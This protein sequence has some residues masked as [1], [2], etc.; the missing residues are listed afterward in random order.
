M[1]AMEREKFR[2]SR[3]ECWFAVFPAILASAV[4]LR[5]FTNTYLS[6]W[7]HSIVALL[8]FPGFI[9]LELGRVITWHGNIMGD[10]WD[11]LSI[12]L[13]MIVT[14]SM[15]RRFDRLKK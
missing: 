12:P 9:A 7:A 5:F 6:V 3:M 15:M 2:L 1:T 4:A 14:V 10:K 8:T 13:S 11:A